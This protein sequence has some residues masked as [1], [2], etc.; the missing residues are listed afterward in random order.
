MIDDCAKFQ[1]D[2][3]ELLSKAIYKQFGTQMRSMPGKTS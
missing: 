3:A 2:N 1:R